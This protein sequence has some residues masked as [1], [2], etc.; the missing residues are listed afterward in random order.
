[1]GYAFT[2]LSNNKPVAKAKELELAC[3]VLCN[4]VSGSIKCRDRVF[5]N[6][7][8]DGMPSPP[9]LRVA[10]DAMHAKVE[11]ERKAP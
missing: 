11:S 7:G 2:I 5:W 1:M 4:V 8:K 10:L 9:R 3:L 6:N